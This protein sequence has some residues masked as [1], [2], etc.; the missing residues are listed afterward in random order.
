MLQQ[1]E[2]LRQVFQTALKVEGLPRHTSTHAPGVV[3]SEEPLT[4]VVPIQDGHEG[5]YLTQY[6]MNY[7][8]DPGF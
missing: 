5:V 4:E 2:E 1:S 8:E 7:L 3:L 6:A